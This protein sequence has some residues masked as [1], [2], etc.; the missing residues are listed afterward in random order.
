MSLA[1]QDTGDFT[2]THEQDFPG[3]SCYSAYYHISFSAH[4]QF[5]SQEELRLNDYT[6]GRGLAPR[7]ADGPPRGFPDPKVGLVP[8]FLPSSIGWRHVSCRTPTVLALGFGSETV[9]LRVGKEGESEDFVIHRNV[10]TARSAFVSEALKGEWREASS[11][12]IPMPDDE[13]E[14]FVL[15][16]QWLYTGCIFSDDRSGPAQGRAR[17]YEI[18]IK[19]YALGEKLMDTIFKDCVVDA[20]S[21]LLFTTQ[22]FNPKLT[23]LVYDMTP[24]GSPLR[25]LW[26]DIYLLCG[27]PSWLDDVHDPDSDF[28]VELSRRQM[29]FTRPQHGAMALL[30]PC[31]Y[32]E[33]EDGKCY[34]TSSISVLNEG[35]RGIISARWR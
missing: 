3:S 28:A 26:Q 9:T 30:D 25:K 1:P 24:Q 33:H 18:L 22:V 17:E 23:Q 27:S 8:V 2:L 29:R 13:P 34:I 14:V 32:H 11:G 15:Y 6:H 21:S 20:I 4:H 16:Q 31:S 19:C 12:I 10:I 35:N 7:R 5:F